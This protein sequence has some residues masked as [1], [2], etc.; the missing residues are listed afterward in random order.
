MAEGT[1]W[2][3]AGQPVQVRAHE[4]PEKDAQKAVPY[5]IY[6]LH[7]DAGW[8]SVGCDGDTAAFAVATLRR[9]WHGEGRHH[10]PG[11]TRPLITADAAWPQR[12]PGP[13]LEEGAGRL[14][15]RDRP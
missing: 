5:G 14:R 15:A 1:E 13:R 11:A 7:A 3:R 12:L 9:W 6:D 2:H 8:V 4:F 10:Y